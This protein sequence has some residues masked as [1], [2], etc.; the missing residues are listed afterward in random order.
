MLKVLANNQSA[1]LGTDRNSLSADCCVCS[2]WQLWIRW[3]K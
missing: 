3:E 2:G 1:I